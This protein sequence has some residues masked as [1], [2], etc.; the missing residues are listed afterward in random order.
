MAGYKPTTTANNQQ[1]QESDTND[2]RQNVHMAMLYPI[3]TFHFESKVH[4]LLPPPSMS[5]AHRAPVTPVFLSKNFIMV[6]DTLINIRRH[7][8]QRASAEG[9]DHAHVG[10]VND[11]GQMC[12][13]SRSSRG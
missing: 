9:E 1:R 3:L 2:P 12:W 8:T 6:H 4:K 11:E 5:E 10:W 13:R 7:I